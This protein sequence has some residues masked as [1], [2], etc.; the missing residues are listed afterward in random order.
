MRFQNVILTVILLTAT[1]LWS[2]ISAQQTLTLDDCRQMALSSN[3]S[4]KTAQEKSYEA[5]ALRKAALSQFFPKLSANGTY[6][7]NQKSI[8][9]LSDSQRDAI[10]NMGTTAM[11][12]VTPALENLATQLLQTDPQLAMALLQSLGNVDVAGDLNSVGQQITDAFDIDM[13]NVFAGAVTVSEPLYMGGKIRALYKTAKLSSEA[14]GIQYDKR[15]DEVLASVD[16]AYWRV[17]S[18][19]HKQKL[20]QQY[21]DLLVRLN[22]DVDAML[23][24]EVATQGDVARVRVKL[25]EAQMSLTRANNGVALARMVLFQLCGLDLSSNAQLAEPETLA[26][27][28]SL[29]TLNMQQIWDNRKD[30]QLLELSRG[31]ARA[32]T[33]MAVSGLLPNVAVTGSYV[34]SNPNLFN[35]YANK[36]G[37]MFTA[38]VAVNIPLCHAGDFYTVKAAKHRQHEVEYQIEEARNLVRLQVNKLNYELEE[39]NHKLAQTQSNLTNA[40]ENLKLADESF[41]AGLISSNDLM[42]AQTAWMSAKSDLIEA[43]IEI[44]MDYVYLK[45]AIGQ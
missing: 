29:D 26:L 17:I 10:N 27:H 44:Q 45:Q 34:V 1:P 42:A 21:C 30:I 38:G 5:E 7:W 11:S 25:N 37:G 8:S 23:A 35:G 13:T 3:S 40:E 39:A 28:Q 24:E 32:N 22:N 33:K 18:L 43:E 15:R 20:A 6:Q 12:Q 4:L 9:L 19:Q 41:K 36:F 31:V 14:A 2:H 16:E